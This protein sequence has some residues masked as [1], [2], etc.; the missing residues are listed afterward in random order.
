MIVLRCILFLFLCCCGFSGWSQAVPIGFWKD[1]LP[2]HR[3]VSVA[4]SAT[5]IYCA[6][7]NGLTI[8]NRSDNS[9]EYLSKANGLSDIGISWIDYHT[10]TRTL[11]ITY[12]NGNIDL[13]TDKE[14]INFSDIKRSSSIQGG[15]AIYRV[16]FAGNQVYLC[17]NFGIVVLDLTKR[18]IRSTLYPQYPSP[19]VY[20]LTAHNDSLYIATSRGLFCAG[21][22]D[23]ALPSPMAWSLVPGFE[24]H[25]RLFS[26]IA[27]FRDTLYAIQ[28]RLSPSPLH[29]DTVFKKKDGPPLVHISE[30]NLPDMDARTEQLLICIPYGAF[31]ERPGEARQELYTYGH[32][33]QV[34][35]PAA[36]I[37]DRND[38]NRIWIADRKYGLVRCD[39]IFDVTKYAS[40]GPHST[41][42]FSLQQGAKKLWV[43][44][45]AYDDAYTPFYIAD[46]VF[47]Y[48]GGT[49]ER[50]ELPDPIWDI[51]SLSADPADPEHLFLSSWGGGVVELQNGTLMQHYARHNSHVQALPADS[52]QMRISASVTDRDGNLWVANAG[53]A[54]PL[55]VRSPNGIWNSFSLGSSVNNQTTGAML[56]DSSGQKWMVVEGRGLVV[57]STEGAALKQFKFINDQTG[58]GALSTNFVKSIAVDREG[59][60]WAGTTKGISVFYNP[61][62]ILS[63]G[64]F[65]WDAQRIIVSQG[66]FNQYLL[67]EEEVTAICVDGG[68]RKWLGTRS[69][70]VFLVSSDGTEQIAHFTTQNSPILSNNI[71]SIAINGATGE[72]F[73]G[74]DMGICSYRSDATTGGATFGN[75]Y[76]F[77]NPVH[78][79]YN[80]TIAITG[81]VTDADVKITD[82]SGNLVFRTIA[83]GGTATWN[84]KLYSG[85]R[86]STGVY[87]VFCTNTDGSETTVTKILFIN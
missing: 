54:R 37:T 41:N 87:L 14:V 18:E 33:S 74:T 36:A 6:N 53:V 22:N 34:P 48:D 63:E 43:S 12:G 84:G 23:P 28:K 73:I 75:V 27:F 25:Q 45:G 65:N 35:E 83:N 64:S 1:H 67:E 52:N 58:S 68:N 78:P 71:N 31:I 24:S 26:H 81:L 72:V 47:S 51:V 66:G 8:L 70:G 15:K 7:P 40:R 56:I 39:H 13:L 19:G 30:Y 42:V 3:S 10:P 86:A 11:V 62:S 60:V 69:A 44:P 2:F 61:E 59:L 29:Y 9:L 55:L 5:H 38:P 20:D 49:W 46:G 21:L 16:R 32:D 17:C 80:G 76:A 50:I 82:V 79:D 77:P 57:F 4:Q 85:D